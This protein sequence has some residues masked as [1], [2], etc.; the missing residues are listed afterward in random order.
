MLILTNIADTTPIDIY[1]AAEQISDIWVDPEDGVTSLKLN[2]GSFYAY[3]AETP[4]TIARMRA[5]WDA[6]FLSSDVHRNNWLPIA[7]TADDKH[8]FRFVCCAYTDAKVQAKVEAAAANVGAAAA[9][10]EVGFD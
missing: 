4:M 5:A 3:I 2:N 6:R 1:V 8:G 7:I 9:S 10:P